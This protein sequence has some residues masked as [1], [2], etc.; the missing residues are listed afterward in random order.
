MYNT[1]SAFEWRTPR[2]ADTSWISDRF[3]QTEPNRAE[4]TDHQQQQPCPCRIILAAREESSPQNNQRCRAC[5]LVGGLLSPNGKNTRHLVGLSGKYTSPPG[6]GKEH[7]ILLLRPKHTHTI[8][9]KY[10]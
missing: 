8:Y 6:Q 7:L 9:S 10:S 3:S 1:A 5:L 4:Q 2:P